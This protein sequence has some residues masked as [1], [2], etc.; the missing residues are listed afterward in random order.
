MRNVYGQFGDKIGVFNGKFV[1]DG[2]GNRIY[3]VED[4]DVFLFSH[5]DEETTLVRPAWV[6][7]G[8]FDGGLATDNSGEFI[9]TIG[10]MT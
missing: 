8:S 1:V 10:K 2:L 7:I 4:Q 6:C 9:F 3:W 5:L